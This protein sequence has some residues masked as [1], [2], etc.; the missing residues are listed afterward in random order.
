MGS[1]PGA[2]PV[3]PTPWR[4][5][6]VRG[7]RASTGT[8]CSDGGSCSFTYQAKV[9]RPASPNV[10]R[11]AAIDS[12]AD[13]GRTNTAHA[14]T[15][16]SVIDTPRRLVASAST[17]KHTTAHG[18]RNDFAKAPSPSVTPSTSASRRGLTLASFSRSNAPNASN[19]AA[20]ASQSGV[21]SSI[22]VIVSAKMPNSTYAATKPH[23]PPSADRLVVRA[24][25]LTAM[26]KYSNDANIATKH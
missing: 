14:P 3:T 9:S 13:Q 12:T 8:P 24:S 11:P 19:V 17:T 23:G 6:S 25:A 7:W 26:S 10:G 15:A 20:D 1:V 5:E 21:V 22:G 4:I 16:I 2:Y 18:T